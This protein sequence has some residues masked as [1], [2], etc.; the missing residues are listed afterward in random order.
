[1]RLP[2]VRFTL[3]WLMLAV[4]LAGLIFAGIAASR[5]AR[6]RRIDLLTALAAYEQA[7]LTREVAAIA[8]TEYVEGIY[9]QELETVKGEILLAK[10][11]RKRAEDRVVWSDR[12]FAKGH[13]SKAQNVAD[14]MSLQ[15]KGLVYEQTQTKLDV[16]EKWTK[17]KTIKE[18]K[19]EVEKARADEWVK[20]IELQR[21]KVAAGR[22]LW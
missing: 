21:A 12:M 8:V 13:V 10:A 14:K 18:L 5:R 2:R 11:E 22:L 4:V 7:H 19:A 1:M 16:L 15:Q 3:R 20:W 17:E 9:K 6:Q